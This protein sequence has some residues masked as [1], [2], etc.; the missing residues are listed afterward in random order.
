[1]QIQKGRRDLHEAIMSLTL[2]FSV[3]VSA[4]FRSRHH[5]FIVCCFPLRYT[6][7]LH[8]DSALMVKMHM[9][10]FSGSLSHELYM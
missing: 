8:S 6:I 1:M 5:R 9:A 10:R 4:S 7:K 2:S 3:S